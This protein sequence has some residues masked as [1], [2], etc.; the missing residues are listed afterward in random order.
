MKIPLSK[1]NEI[2][3]PCSNR[4]IFLKYFTFFTV[5]VLACSL[6][7]KACL[8]GRFLLSFIIFSFLSLVAAIYN[9]SVL[10]HDFFW[11]VQVLQH[12]Q[13]KPNTIVET[14]EY[15]ELKKGRL[16]H[17]CLRQQPEILLF[18]AK[19]LEHYSKTKGDANKLETANK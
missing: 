18:I 7:I 15:L 11:I 14:W 1:I 9:F 12:I 16:I 10:R 4:G 2:S 19:L 3:Y 5:S 6:C 17:F 8:N 13:K